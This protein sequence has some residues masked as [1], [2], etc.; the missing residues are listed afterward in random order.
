MCPPAHQDQPLLPISQANLEPAKARGRP[1][2]HPTQKMES[3]KQSSSGQLNVAPVMHETD[4]P[5]ISVE[6]LGFQND[7][8]SSKSEIDEAKS[9]LLRSVQIK[10]TSVKKSCESEVETDHAGKEKILQKRLR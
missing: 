2:K 5:Q 7:R 8:G 10:V 9:I 4:E 1:R 3:E 6:P